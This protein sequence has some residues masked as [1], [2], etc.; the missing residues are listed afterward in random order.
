MDDINESEGAGVEQAV[1]VDGRQF[2][3]PDSALVRAALDLLSTHV[4]DAAG[5]STSCAHCGLSCPCPTV[6][7]AR[8]VVSAGGLVSTDSESVDTG[9]PGRVAVEPEAE[10]DVVVLEVREP[11]AAV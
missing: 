2:L 8:Q 11:V 6:Q 5:E 1:Q 4:V 3:E 7:H 9:D 10:P